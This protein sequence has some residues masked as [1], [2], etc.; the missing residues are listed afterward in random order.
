MSDSEGATSEGDGGDEGEGERKDGGRRGAAELDADMHHREDC[1][2]ED[3]ASTQVLIRIE[4]AGGQSTEHGGRNPERAYIDYREDDIGRMNHGLQINRD[5]DAKIASAERKD[6]EK[7]GGAR[8]GTDEGTN[9]P[10]LPDRYTP[11][12]TEM[13]SGN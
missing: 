8:S 1:S 9:V 3:T 12:P 6:E 11:K 2:K 13:P 7:W 4:N 5:E 10:H